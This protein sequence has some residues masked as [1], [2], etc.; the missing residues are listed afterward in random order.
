MGFLMKNG[1]PC[2]SRADSTII[3]KRPSLLKGGRFRLIK[4]LLIKYGRYP[5]ILGAVV[6]VAQAVLLSGFPN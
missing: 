2:V 6:F 5:M 3:K 4:R 1:W